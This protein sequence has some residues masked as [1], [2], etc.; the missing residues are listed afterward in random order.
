MIKNLKEFKLDLEN[1]YKVVV[2]ESHL[3][4]QKKIAT[5]LHRFIVAGSPDGAPGTPV[6]WGWARANWSVWVGVAAPKND[7]GP[8]QKVATKDDMQAKLEAMK[9]LANAKPF[10]I[11]WVY[12]NV[13]YIEALEDGHSKQAPVG[14]VETALN[15]LQT[16]I[17]NL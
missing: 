14:M 9:A 16:V 17:D 5:T 12:N 2:P 3:E 7:P 15:S 11:I 8:R 4:Y 10:Q 13:P 1:F 6:D